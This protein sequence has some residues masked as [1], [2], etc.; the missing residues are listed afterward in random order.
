MADTTIIEPLLKHRSGEG[1]QE[2]TIDPELVDNALNYA[3]KIGD[4]A[5]LEDFTVS[6]YATGIK[7]ADTSG[8]ITD[9]TGSTIGGYDTYVIGDKEAAVRLGNKYEIVPSG[10]YSRIAEESAT[11]FTN[12]RQMWKFLEPDGEVNESL[13]ET[14]G[15]HRKAGGF[16]DAVVR[17]DRMSC[18]VNASVLWPKWVAGHLHYETVRPTDVHLLFPTE[19]VDGDSVE[20]ATRG[21]IYSDMEDCLAVGIRL[22]SVGGAGSNQSLWI[23]YVGRSDAWPLGRC[24]TFEAQKWWP[25]PD[26]DASDASIKDD[27]TDANGEI[28]NPLTALQEDY[29]D[30]VL[31]EYPLIPIYGSDA[32]TDKRVL[33]TSASL[34]E[35]CLELDSAGSRNITAASN[36]STGLLIVKDPDNAGLPDTMGGAVALRT[37]QDATQGGASASNAKDAG[38]VFDNKSREIAESEGVPGYTVLAGKAPE[39]AAAL[40]I[41]HQPQKDRREKRI[42][43]N[44]GAVQKLASIERYLL[45]LHTDYTLTPVTVQW[46]A[47][48]WQPP[49][50]RALLV[51]E[52]TAAKEANLIDHIE[53]V[54]RYH[55]LDTRQEAR[56]YLDELAADEIQYGTG[57]PSVDRAV[58]AL[59]PR[60]RQTAPVKPGEGDEQDG[61]NSMSTS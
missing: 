26:P 50:P 36:A 20:G 13:D 54:R 17:W 39:S 15:A 40:M 58:N 45:A 2:T 49:M 22:R 51:E 47:G 46:D 14:I 24:C 1:V 38:I 48:E 16:S 34:F 10:L 7:R 59:V 21:P 29:P 33:P 27:W 35:R 31:Y 19:I 28:A 57:T 60:P 30:D 9:S 56:E 53:S 43:L 3:D 42:K 55:K 6:R 52:L 5:I 8:E 18:A 4:R 41:R 61:K 12:P 25:L 23:V 32:G 44:G 37:G 11:L